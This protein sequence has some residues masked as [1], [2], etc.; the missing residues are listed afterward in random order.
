[1]R[2]VVRFSG[3]K[4]VDVSSCSLLSFLLLQLSYVSCDVEIKS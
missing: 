2:D 1:M 3:E 4:H